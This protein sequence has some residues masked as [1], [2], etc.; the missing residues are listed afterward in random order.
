MVPTVEEE[1]RA[2]VV[3]CRFL[4]TPALGIIGMD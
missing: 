4:G 1:R 3:R 2:A